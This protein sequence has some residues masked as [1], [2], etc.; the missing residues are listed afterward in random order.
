MDR[1]KGSVLIIG[2][3]IDTYRVD[4]RKFMTILTTH[5]ESNRGQPAA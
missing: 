3:N 1:F 5:D 2:G 4:N